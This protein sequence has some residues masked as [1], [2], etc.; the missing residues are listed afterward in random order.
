MATA[1]VWFR[2]DLRLSDNPA[3]QAALRAGYAPVPVYIHAPEE[4][5]PWAPGAASDA[6]RRRSLQALDARLRQ[7]GSRL[8]VFAGPSL[9]TLQRVAAACDA[10]AVFWNRRYEPTIEQ[11][12]AAIKREL[13]GAGLRAE[14]HNAALLFE[15]WQIQS[16]QGDPYRVF[17]PFWRTALAQWRMPACTEPP[18][19]LPE[20][21]SIAGSTSV[22]ELLAAPTPAWDTGFWH[23]WTPGEAGG[24]QALRLFADDAVRDYTDARDRP[25]LRGTS[26]LSPHLHFGELSPWRI[27]RALEG[28]PVDE[29]EAYVRQLGWREFAHHVLHHFPHTQDANFDARF[30]GFDWNALPEAHR[31]AWQQGRTG[32]PLV[33]AGMRELWATGWMHNRVRMVVASFLGKNL[34]AHWL[35]GARWF[36]QTLVDADLAN[37]GLG[38][39]W[40][41]GTGVDAAPYVRVFNPTLQAQRFDPQGAYIARWLPGFDRLPVALRHEPWRDAEAVKSAAPDYPRS[42]IVDLAASRQAALEA[43]SRSRK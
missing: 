35:E 39:Q 29:R 37:N 5:G 7:R 26:R 41:C 4:E 6:W 8:Q 23:Q 10:E 33:D 20:P 9:S 11:R 42:P 21:G 14:S 17:T 25:A 34:R 36:W 15:P 1:I 24:E 19:T 30:D 28:A 3:L 12:D 38:W 31:Q 32:V 27:V 40:V 22:D 43:F 16:R 18:P 13:R 2:D